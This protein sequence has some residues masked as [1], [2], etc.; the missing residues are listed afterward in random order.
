MRDMEEL[1]HI[2]AN[3]IEDFIGIPPDKDDLDVRIIRQ[4]AAVR[5][6]GDPFGG[7]A[8]IVPDIMGAA[9]RTFAQVIENL[10]PIRERSERIAD[11]HEP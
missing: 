9:W 2:T 7:G 4:K 3:P 5:L 11:P 8:D 6:F 10:L 1:D